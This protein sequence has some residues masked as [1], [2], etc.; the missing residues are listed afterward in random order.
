M[1]IYRHRFPAKCPGNGRMVEYAITIQTSRMIL[2]EDIVKACK[3]RAAYHEDIA[4]TLYNQFGGFQIMTAHHHGVD[5]ETHR[6]K[7]VDL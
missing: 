1:N 4:E 5:I 2:V 3:A 7:A 6:G